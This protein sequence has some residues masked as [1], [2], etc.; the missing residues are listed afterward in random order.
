MAAPTTVTA[1]GAAATGAASAEPDRVVGA[2]RVLAVL[3][4]LAKHTQGASLDEL[5]TVIRAPK[6]T[7]H[8]ALASLRRAGLA[9][10]DGHGHYI[11]GDEFLRLAF[12]H[13]EG[14]PDHVRVTGILERLA[15]RYG[16][17]AHYAVLDGR[18]VVYRSKVDPLVGAVKLSSTVGGRNPAH[19]TAV[20]K[21][22]LS[23]ELPTLDAVRDWIG[24]EPLEARTETTAA[25]PEALHDQL[26]LIR[27]RGYSI[28]D[29]ENEAG[30]NCLALPAFLAS[31]TVPTGGISISGLA[32]RMPIGDLVRDLSA[33]RAIVSGAD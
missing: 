28:D 21:L 22:L 24:D 14:R 2:D 18:W 29:Q 20:G 17:T 7:V 12:A 4:E 26:E 16:E 19:S 11:L 10:Q 6:P 27:E 9:A 25:T 30:V 31:P 32:Y 13:A 15:H 8:R 23:Y 33:I 3:V 5:V 1:T